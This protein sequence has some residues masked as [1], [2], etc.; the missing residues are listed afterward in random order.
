[1]FLSAYLGF[2]VWGPG[3]PLF[4]ATQS[5]KEGFLSDLLPWALQK[6]D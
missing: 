6:T 5:W 1:M 3:L 2:S 4:L